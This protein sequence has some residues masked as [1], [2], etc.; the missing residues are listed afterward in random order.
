MCWPNYWWWRSVL[1]VA[2]NSACIV[3]GCSKGRI[4]PQ[5]WPY[6]FLP[7]WGI[8]HWSA[9]PNAVGIGQKF[10]ILKHTVRPWYPGCAPYLHHVQYSTWQF[11]IIWWLFDHLS[12]WCV[13]LVVGERYWWSDTYGWIFSWR[14]GCWLLW[15]RSMSWTFFDVLSHRLLWDR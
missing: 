8:C 11:L 15:I 3:F 12:I 13:G 14:H 10:G 5:N 7:M 9:K 2:M 4:H 6:M 1:K